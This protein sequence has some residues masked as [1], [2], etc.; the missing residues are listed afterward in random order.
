MTI[1]NP[2]GRLFNIIQAG[3]KEKNDKPAA[4]AWSNILDVPIKDKVLL[5]TRIG[6]VM[7]LPGSIKEEIE[8]LE[9]ID[10]KLHLKWL[11]K[12]EKCFSLL[13]FQLPWS[14]F[15]DKFDGEIVYGMQIC[16]DVLSRNRPEKV[17]D[18]DIIKG[19]L[20]Q[21]NELLKDLENE[22]LPPNV[23][24]FIYEH[25]CIAKKALEEYKIRGIKPLEA[26][27]ER[28]TGA[29]VRSPWV[30]LQTRK[31]SFGERFWKCMG[32]LAVATTIVVGG[33]QIGHEVF[34][35]LSYAQSQDIRD[36]Q[37]FEI[38]INIGSNVY[39]NLNADTYTKTLI[40]L[41][42]ENKGNKK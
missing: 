39:S 3:K 27:V 37:P 36:E 19:L 21:V 20:P 1:N 2:A 42:T 16:S 6:H 38:Y 33:I 18:P 14:Q 7:A 15:I 8:N 9:N 41:P 11:P 29:V 31:S 30:W 10:H 34:D 12:V 40:A 5:L 28:L 13:N 26:E 23:R 25:L 32:H 17:A 4:E 24:Q 22:N 35:A